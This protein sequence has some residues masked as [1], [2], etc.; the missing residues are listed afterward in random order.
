[1]SPFVQQPTPPFASVKSI[2]KNGVLLFIVF[3]F[4]IASLEIFFRIIRKDDALKLSMG[5][6]DSEFHHAFEPNSSLHMV[7]SIL[8]EFDVWAHINNVGFRGSDLRNE[9]LAGQ[10]R[11]FV[12]GDS[13]TFG[14]G[15]EDPETIPE[16]IQKHLDPTRQKIEVVNGG[17]GHDSPLTYSMRLRRE[18]PLLKPDLVLMLLDFSDLWED[19]HNEKHA[20]YNSSGSIIGINP[21]YEF[22]KFNVWN[23]LRSKSVFCGYLHNKVVRTALKI[24]KLGFMGY[25]QT[26]LK[27]KK[28]KAVISKLEGETIAF[29]GRL[30]LRGS[31]K[32]DEITEHFKRTASY[33]LKCRDL[34]TASGADFILVM[35]P[36]GVQVGPNQWAEGRTFWGFEQ[37]Q[38][39]DDPFS[40]DLVADFA[41]KNQI[42]FINLW[43]DLKRHKDEILFF[44]FDGH[45][46][47]RANEIAAEALSGYLRST[48]TSTHPNRFSPPTFSRQAQ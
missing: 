21:L 28:A 11:I 18:V 40:F 25:I 43:E 2:L 42:A 44:P 47:P 15:A 23:F 12:V 34:V 14:V 36:Y 46:T 3:I 39:Y 30:F 24:K 4:L 6:P 32:A 19:W 16:Q 7:S 29:D 33:I 1:M 37:G 31:Q 10:K 38:V 41:A 27:G 17:R 5:H 9:K 22:G 45:F 26:K 8:G 48:F 35:Y 20:I 13:F